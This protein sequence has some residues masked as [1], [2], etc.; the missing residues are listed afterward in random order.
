MKNIGIVILVVGSLLGLVFIQY[1]LLK[2]GILLEKQRFD[3]KVRG[4]LEEVSERIDENEV[5]R[6]NLTR[7]YTT[8]VEDLRS[9]E[10]L[11]PKMLQDS[12]EQLFR[13][14]LI[15]ADLQLKYTYQLEELHTDKVLV[16]AKPSN[17]T[18]ATYERYKK[19]LLG[20][21]AV[22][23]RCQPVLEFRVEHVLNY[24]YRRLAY[25]IVPSVL[26]IL[27]LL[28]CLFL[29]IY[30]LNRQRQLDRVKNDFINNLTHELKTPVFSISLITKVLRK[31][32]NH[33]RKEKAETYIQLIDKE[34]EQ[35]KQHIEKV[36]ELASLESGKY[37]L[38]RQPSDLHALLRELIAQF[39]IK[40]DQRQ[41][42]I[43]EQFEA[44]KSQLM[45]DPVHFRNAILNILENALKYN[46]KVPEI[47]V[48]T[49]TDPAHFVL[50]IHDNGV[51]IPVED[52]K[53]IFDKFYRVS[54]GNI[55]AVKGFGLGLSYVKQIIEA[56]GGSITVSSK[57]GKGTEF[58]VEIPLKEHQQ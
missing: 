24:L 34:N 58:R 18:N 29:L 51:G 52:Q 23:C 38:Q 57:P 3:V 48:R 44:I 9:P 13:E 45:I 26:F 31:A 36:L 56:H 25:L 50:S 42:R 40:L 10:Y 11:L 14:E 53:H 8:P 6:Q 49:R 12:L 32:I 21:V 41:G 20:R 15:R 7:L 30:N 55:H 1:H 47:I 27:L 39:A 2:V 28:G 19:Y 16:P 5:I 43:L 17:Y 22:D 33:G 54:Q 4:M 37:E 46:D 35:L